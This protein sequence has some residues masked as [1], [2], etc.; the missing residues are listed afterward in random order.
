LGDKAGGQR[1]AAVLRVAMAQ[2]G[3]E[4]WGQLADASGVSPTTLDNW[5]YGVTTPRAHH[6]GLVGKALAPFTSGG[7]LERAYSGLE[8]EEPPIIDALREIIPELHELVVLLRAQADASVLEA[9]RFALEESRQRRAAGSSRL[10]ERP[11]PR[12][13]NYADDE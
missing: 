8:P 10:Y 13:P 6:L 4:T 7:D 11:V 12:G 3:I 9:V 5:V 2:K 1:L